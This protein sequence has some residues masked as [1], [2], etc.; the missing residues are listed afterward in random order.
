MIDAVNGIAELWWSWMGPMLWQSS[1]L[2]VVIGVI[3]RL[4]HRWAWPEVRHALWLLVLIKL[5]IPPSWSVSGALFPPLLEPVRQQV[6]DRIA[7]READPG[8]AATPESLGLNQG[9]QTLPAPILAGNANMCF[10][11]LVFWIG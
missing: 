5:V 11:S 4:I 7:A 9:R 8:A 6:G 1:L 10:G 3:D 2:I